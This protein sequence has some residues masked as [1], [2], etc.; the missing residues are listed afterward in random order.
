MAGWS[1]ARTASF[2]SY[3]FGVS[4][5][6]CVTDGSVV[7]I[8]VPSPKSQKYVSPR[9][10]PRPVRENDASKVTVE[11]RN[12]F[13]GTVSKYAFGLALFGSAPP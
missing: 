8:V 7:A 6:T 1:A 5:N 11:V 3:H 12:G 13:A 4:A 9:V 2:T 10:P